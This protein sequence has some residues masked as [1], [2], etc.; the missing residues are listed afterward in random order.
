MFVAVFLPVYQKDG[1]QMQ[2][3]FS[4]K[5][6]NFLSLHHVGSPRHFVSRCKL[7]E[8]TKVLSLEMNSLALWLQITRLSVATHNKNM[9]YL[10]VCPQYAWMEIT[11][12]FIGICLSRKRAG[13]EIVPQYFLRPLRSMSRP[14]FIFCWRK[15]TVSADSLTVRNGVNFRFLPIFYGKRNFDTEIYSMWGVQ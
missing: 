11:F 10:N 15:G 5:R 4:K 13:K 14:G 12:L 8:L 1:I 9:Q 3:F 6:F 2:L 7:I